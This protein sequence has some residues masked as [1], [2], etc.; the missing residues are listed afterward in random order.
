MNVAMLYFAHGTLESHREDIR[1]IRFA[2]AKLERSCMIL[3]DLPGLNTGR[4]KTAAL[5]Y[6]NH[7]GTLNVPGMLQHQREFI[8]DR[9]S[10]A[11]NDDS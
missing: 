5:G 1:R 7:G 3:D 4:G 10:H 11:D 2:A 6:I 9:R 8:Q